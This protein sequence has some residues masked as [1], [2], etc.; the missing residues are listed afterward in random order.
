MDRVCASKPKRTVMFEYVARVE[1]GSLSEKD[2]DGIDT[3]QAAEPD[4][5]V[6]DRAL[7]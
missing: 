7:N 3:L 2:M 4:Y 5:V 6:S 1:G